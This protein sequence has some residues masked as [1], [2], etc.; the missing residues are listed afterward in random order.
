MTDFKNKPVEFAQMPTSGFK[1]YS[2]SW[3]ISTKGDT[4]TKTTKREVNMDD[5]EVLTF[6]ISEKQKISF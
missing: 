6:T 2:T 1:S 4:I 5:G 3:N